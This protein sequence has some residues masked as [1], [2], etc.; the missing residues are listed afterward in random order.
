MKVI[1]QRYMPLIF[2]C[3]FLGTSV[4]AQKFESTTR[5]ARHP[6]SHHQ[7]NRNLSKS[8]GEN[9]FFKLKRMSNPSEQAQSAQNHSRLIAHS[10]YFYDGVMYIPED[11]SRLYYSGSNADPELIDFFLGEINGLL[12]KPWILTINEDIELKADSIN[13]FYW[14]SGSETFQKNN[15]W[16]HVF[17]NNGRLISETNYEFNGT[18]W[19][20][21]K[22]YLH[23]YNAQGLKTSKMLQIWTGSIWETNRK[24]E[25]DYDAQNNMTEH[26]QYVWH[27]VSSSWKGDLKEIAIYEGTK[28]ITLIYQYGNGDTFY[29]YRRYSMNYT[30]DKLTEL[31]MDSWP[32]ESTDWE[33]SQKVVNTYNS[34]GQLTSEKWMIWNGTDYT[35]DYRWTFAFDESGKQLNAITQY[36][37]SGTWIY[38]FKYDFEH[39]E[40]A[41]TAAIYYQWSGS[42][43]EMS[44]KIALENNSY[45]QPTSVN[46]FEWDGNAFIPDLFNYDLYFY[47]EEYSS[48][49][50]LSSMIE[51][52]KITI[53]PN[54]AHD[55]VNVKLKDQNINHI[56]IRDITGKVV[57]ETQSHFNS[58]EVQIP[59]NQLQ[60]GV[61]VLQLM[62]GNEVG[63]SK[64]VVKR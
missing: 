39:E 53:Y 7:L 21:A 27:N 5:D 42:E 2:G 28:L 40:D 54:P 35:N 61:Y 15:K 64:F 49:T 37:D 16:I 24:N 36:W 33:Q 14:N 63:S 45:G 38:D 18:N 12:A 8:D 62:S 51:K 31:V 58:G 59:I 11:S 48:G 13:S 20:Y 60:N 22:R 43:L 50:G 32:W 4:N 41:L 1:L 29:N 52:D 26:T 56:L 10:E 30:G 6:F 34:N 55:F 46:F 47:Y 23:S 57:F 17:D 3:V 25:F 19:E 9:N 44:A